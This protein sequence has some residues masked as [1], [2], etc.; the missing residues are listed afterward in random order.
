MDKPFD[1]PVL[2]GVFATLVL[3][4]CDPSLA[5][6]PAQPSPAQH[7]SYRYDGPAG[8][9]E[10]TR[11][12]AEGG[13]EVLH[14]STDLAGRIDGST[15]LIAR[16]EVQIDARGRLLHAELIV[17]NPGAADE[18]RYTL[19]ANGGTVHVERSGSASFDWR[20]P[21]DAPWLYAPAFDGGGALV[22]TP[23]GAWVALR[24]ASAAGAANVVRVLEPEQQR[25]YLMTVDQVAVATELGTTVALGYDGVDADARFI[26]ELRLFRGEVKLARV[27]TLDL[28]A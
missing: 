2:P 4:A 5:S 11:E 23:V 9:S 13:P 22:V 12:R 8:S 19:D 10:V 6:A 27:A 26:N 14:G 21:V 20:V 15:R 18:A 24:A 16:E 28:G 7:A 1:R 17:G 25:T 3:G